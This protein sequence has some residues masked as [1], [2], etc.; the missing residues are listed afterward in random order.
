MA[1]IS[2][3]M[4]TYNGEKYIR[5]QLD[6]ILS[7]TYPVYEIVIQDDG[8][9]DSTMEILREYA[10]CHGF[11][12]VYQNDHNIGLFRNFKTATMRATGDFIALSDQ[13]DVWYPQ[14]LEKQVTAIGTNDLCYSQH[15]RGRDREDVRLVAY[16]CAPE[17]QLFSVIVG[18]SFLMRRS[19]AQDEGNWMEC[20][21]FHDISLG[22][23]A[24]FSNGVTCV[25][26]PLNWHRSHECQASKP[27]DSTEKM[28][29]WGRESWKPYLYGC[30]YLRRMQAT[31]AFQQ[32]YG[33]VARRS[34]D[35]NA[36]VY[37]MCRLMQSKGLL[38]LLE[39]CFLCLKHRKTVYPTETHGM[40][41]MVRGFF[42]PFIYA[43]HNDWF[44]R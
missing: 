1:K 7:Q 33:E 32:Y 21:P 29:E 4:A 17:R 3:V 40:S 28:Q 19:Y 30:R 6:S 41:G 12:H 5:E 39:L 27:Q 25:D 42:Y 31:P 8:S 20:V 38:S 11:I 14:K 34:K 24:H 15:H 10:A 22:L 16:K 9:T 18:H 44:D 26:E 35:K 37:K 36:L 23:M 2:V 43:Y 13:D